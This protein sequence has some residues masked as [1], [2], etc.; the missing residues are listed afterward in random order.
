MRTVTHSRMRCESNYVVLLRGKPGIRKL[1][2][3]H[4]H[5]ILDMI[6]GQVG[7]Q[8]IDM[9]LFSR[10]MLIFAV[11]A[12]ILG[13]GNATESKTWHVRQDGSGDAPSIQAA[14]DSSGGGDSILVAPGIYSQKSML[15]FSKD[16]LTMK[17]EQGAGQTFLYSLDYEILDVLDSRHI[18][19]DGFTFENSP[20]WAFGAGSSEY[21]TLQGN[22]MRHAKQVAI[23]LGSSTNVVI[24]GNLIYSNDAGIN[25]A[26]LSSSI[27]VYGNTIAHNAIDSCIMNVL[28]SGLEVDHETLWKPG[29]SRAAART[30]ARPSGQGI[31]A[32]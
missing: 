24:Q 20:R 28:Y 32:C 3:Q 21:V 29:D 6:C 22:V 9:M 17:S 19:I 27:Y 25:C 4:P 13:F 30:S 10:V 12:G 23:Q 1:Y 5:D 8:G 26:N 15:I 11:N 18:T 2:E 31:S 7:G 16:S 14:I